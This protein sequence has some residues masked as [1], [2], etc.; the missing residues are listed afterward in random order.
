MLIRCAILASA[1]WHINRIQRE[2]GAKSEKME[3]MWDDYCLVH[4]TVPLHFMH[5]C[6]GVVCVFVVFCAALSE[7]VGLVIA[8][9]EKRG[10]TLNSAGYL[11]GP[12]GMDSHRA[13]SS[14]Y[15][16]A[17][18]RDLPRED[19]FKSSVLRI[20]D[21]NVIHTIIDF[22]SYLKLKEM[23]ALEKISPSLTSEELGQA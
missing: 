3:P 22:L 11:L 21:E 8:G 5:K 18:K 7:T 23:G 17:G 6:V 2:W 12:H 16:L 9:K 4:P 14:K 10:W 20:A 1:K 13:F 15:G 19:D